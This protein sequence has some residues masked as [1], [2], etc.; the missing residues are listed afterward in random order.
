MKTLQPLLPQLPLIG[1]NGQ[2]YMEK[3]DQVK[4]LVLLEQ[5]VLDNVRQVLIVLR[6]FHIVQNWVIAMEA[7]YPL[8]KLS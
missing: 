7:G 6:E 5:V 8:M 2:K 1:A 4:E 3:K